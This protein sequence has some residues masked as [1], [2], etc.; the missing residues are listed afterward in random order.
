MEGFKSRTL[1]AVYEVHYIRAVKFPLLETVE[2]G[3]YRS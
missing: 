1:G 3:N 2:S